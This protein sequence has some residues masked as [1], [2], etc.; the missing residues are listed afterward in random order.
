MNEINEKIEDE[1]NQILDFFEYR[2]VSTKSQKEK[3][4]IKRQELLNSKFLEYNKNRYNVVRAFVDDGR[5]G[6]KSSKEDRPAY[7]RMMNELKKEENHSIA[8]VFVLKVNRL[9]RD[10]QELVNFKEK[11]KDLG[12]SVLLAESGLLLSFSNPMEELIFDIQAGISNYVGKTI[13]NKMQFMRQVAYDEDPDKFGRPKKEI[14]ERLKKKII[15]LYRNQKQGFLKICKLLRLEDIKD[16]PDWFQRD[17]PNGFGKEE[18]QF[19]LSPT[20]IGKRLKEW[21]IEIRS[22][23]FRK[24]KGKNKK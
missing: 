5:S 3:C 10:T 22:P 13:I 12:K 11:I 15:N 24:L 16:Y 23:K 14:P 4:T 19:Y 17:H 7:W 18:G 1:K 20:T 6:F 8:G 21:G 9:G 2:R